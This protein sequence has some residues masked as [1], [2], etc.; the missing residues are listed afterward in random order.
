[1]CKIFFVIEVVVVNSLSGGYDLVIGEKFLIFI[2]V[3]EGEKDM[4]KAFP[5]LPVA[6]NSGVIVV[7]NGSVDAEQDGIDDTWERSMFGNL[8]V[9]NAF[10]DWDRDG[11]SDVQE[12]LNQLAG[13]TDPKGKVYNPKEKNAAGGTG[14]TAISVSLPWLQL[15]L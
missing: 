3:V 14:Y 10:T 11:Y 9:A 12:Y 15:L 1:M 8:D 5:A 6:L 13:E 7:R 2:G 4:S